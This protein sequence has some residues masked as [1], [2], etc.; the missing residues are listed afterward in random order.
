MPDTPNKPSNIAVHPT[1]DKN[2]KS[3]PTER[4]G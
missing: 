1:A 2:I 4:R 3:S